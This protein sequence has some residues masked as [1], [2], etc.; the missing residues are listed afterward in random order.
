MLIWCSVLSHTVPH[1][2]TDDWTEFQFYCKM[3]IA[4]RYLS[5]VSLISNNRHMGRPLALDLLD[6]VWTVAQRCR[7]DM[8]EQSE[9]QSRWLLSFLKTTLKSFP[10][11]KQAATERQQSSTPAAGALQPS[12]CFSELILSIKLGLMLLCSLS[13]TPLLPL[14]VYTEL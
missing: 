12:C 3:N 1:T 5:T 7:H 10:K 8:T 6:D 4:P 9:V 13:S 2:T 14:P 11:P